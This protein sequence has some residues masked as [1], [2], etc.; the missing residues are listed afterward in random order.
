LESV[1][2]YELGDIEVMDGVNHPS[3]R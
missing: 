2:P 1:N 3:D